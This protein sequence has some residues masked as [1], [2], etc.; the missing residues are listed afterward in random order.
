MAKI[1]I[2]YKNSNILTQVYKILR[3]THIHNFLNVPPIYCSILLSMKKL[4]E[5]LNMENR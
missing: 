5:I 1:K 4:S 2:K 3:I